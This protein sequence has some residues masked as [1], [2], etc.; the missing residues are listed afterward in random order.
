MSRTIRR[1]K[2]Q[3]MPGKRHNTHKE[4]ICTPYKD[5][6][7]PKWRFHSDMMTRHL[8]F[9]YFYCEPMEPANRTKRRRYKLE[10]IKWLKNPD[11]EI[12]F[13]RARQIWDY[14]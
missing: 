7:I 9:Q 6:I 8:S 5:Y 10:V 13:Q 4:I 14:W 1:I 12:Q 2:K 3:S 11:Y